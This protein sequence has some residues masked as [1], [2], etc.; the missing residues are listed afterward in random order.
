VLNRQYVQEHVAQRPRLSYLLFFLFGALTMLSFAPVG[1]FA[2]AP[3]L[4]LPL[5]AACLYLPAKKVA[6]LGFCYGSGLFLTGTYWLYISIHVF[7]QA[8]LW[9][10][11]II[12]LGLV[13][14]MGLYYALTAWLISRLSGGHPVTFLL[15]APAVWVAVE[16]IR[17][18]F[19]SGFPWMSL[20]YSQIDTTLA[21]LAPVVGVYGLSLALLI[22]TTAFLVAV[23]STGRKR[24]M[25]VLLAV[26]PWIS[27]A[28]FQQHEWT[29]VTGQP[30]R[31]TIVQ[32]G[33]SQERKWAREQFWPTLNLYRSSIDAHPDSELIVWPEVA[34]PATIDQV[35]DYLDEIEHAVKRRGQSLL[36]GI[37]ERQAAEG[38]IYNS[39]VMMGG[40]SRQI[41][42]KR[43]LVPFGEYFPVPDFVRQ[44][45]R[46]MSLPNTDLGSG[47][48][49]QALL[50]TASGTRLAIAICYEDA[51]GAEQ[52]YAFPEASILINVS[53]DAWFGDSI[54]PHQH[55]EIARMRALEVGRYVVRSTNNGV[56]AFIGPDGAILER[57]PQFEYVAMTRDISPLGGLTPYARFGNW[58]VIS[59]CLLLMA[60]VAYRRSLS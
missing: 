46:M 49:E 57:G 51:Y 45:M 59:L 6:R 60:A 16:W 23:I 44:W 29:E 42:R 34:L 40:K 38:A 25:A 4:L 30:V 17:G 53:N 5:L 39:M 43:H 32:G 19:L 28:I 13:M 36:L 14:I 3:I 47:A 50:V 21:G 20:G 37:L 26:L 41:Y 9:V 55:L 10:A 27:G 33:V 48:A 54:A 1:W 15:V 12:M 58:P 35:E 2:V 18:W 56:S 31:T 52:L 24:T 22:S 11:L 7:G 8:P